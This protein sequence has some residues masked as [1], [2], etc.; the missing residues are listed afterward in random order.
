MSFGGLFDAMRR[1]EGRL[2]CKVRPMDFVTSNILWIAVAIVSGAALI[3][4]MFRNRSVNSVTPTQ[5]V[6]LLN[7]QHGI[8]ID[9][10]TQEEQEKTKI[11]KALAIPL[12]DLADKL[13]DLTKYKSRPVILVCATGTRS[14]NG[15]SILTKAGFEQVFN[16]EGG[17]KAWKDAGQPVLNGNKS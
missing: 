3:Y 17:L 14:V 13:N 7:R 9:V 12:A 15:V 10:R 16:L 2:T 5:A 11:A 4:P 6:M 1:T 8:L